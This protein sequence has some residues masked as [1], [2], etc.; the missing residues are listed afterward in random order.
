MVGANV[1]GAIE[2]ASVPMSTALSPAASGAV[3][4]PGVRVASAAGPPVG[5]GVA[6][7]AAMGG[8][9]TLKSQSMSPPIS[10]VSGTQQGQSTNG[11]CGFEDE[12]RGGSASFDLWY[13]RVSSYG[14]NA[15]RSQNLASAEAL[16]VWIGKGI[17]ALAP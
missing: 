8:A 3:V 4:A 16:G 5:D 13:V 15:P 11:T 10:Y 6:S 7:G 2:G 14:K 1:S 9:E 12:C 17:T